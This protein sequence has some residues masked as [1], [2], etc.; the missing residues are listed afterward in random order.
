LPILETGVVL[1]GIADVVAPLVEHLAN[2]E[3]DQLK[4]TDFFGREM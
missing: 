1:E 4:S 2:P 3:S